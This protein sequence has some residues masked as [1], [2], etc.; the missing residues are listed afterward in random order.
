MHK[1][2]VL[3]L[4]FHSPANLL[5]PK[6]KIRTKLFYQVTNHAASVN[7]AYT[8]HLHALRLMT[9]MTAQIATRSYSINRHCVQN[10]I[11]Y[12]HFTFID[13]PCPITI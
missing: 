3:T 10:F 13:L 1:P 2:I 5:V 12:Q 8:S 4:V 11:E 7:L 6:I 9:V